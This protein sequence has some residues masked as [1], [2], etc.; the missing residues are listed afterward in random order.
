M[1][2][3]EQTFPSL[4]KNNAGKTDVITVFDTVGEFT[5][6]VQAMSLPSHNH[7]NSWNGNERI[8][9]TTR[10]CRTGDLARVA[11]SEE[12]MSK[13]EALIG[14]NGQKFARV[15]SVAGGAPNV[16]AY[17][18]GNPMNMRK[19]R[20]VVDDQAP[21]NIVVDCVSSA[22]IDAATLEKRGAAI[23]ALV[24]ILSATRPVS[25]YIGA[26]AL[27]YCDAHKLTSRAVVA[28]LDSAPLDL[29]RAAHLL[30]ATGVSRQMA[31]GFICSDGGT[32]GDDTGLGWGYD[33][34]AFQ[35]KHG[36]EYWQRSL[37]IG[38][39]L[40]I[41][42]PYLTDDIVTAPEKW[43]KQMIAEYGKPDEE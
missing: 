42:A 26:Q 32:R 1:A 33:S 4:G 12:M 14:Y 31:Y 43:L 8:E 18:A 19:R 35:R 7:G 37:G 17:L 22:G 2:R 13:F 21:L 34:E 28:R 24:R 39:M 41:A 25:L 40:Y 5:D 27:P 20:R 36:K 38:E 30:C 29:A 3:F 11:A 6:A 23:L 9:E 16:S 15:S 10:K